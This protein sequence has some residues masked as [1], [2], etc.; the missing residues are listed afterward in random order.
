MESGLVD[1]FAFIGSSKAADALV[2]AGG[3]GMRDLEG[4]R[5]QGK[6]A[7]KPGGGGVRG[8][9][10]VWSRIGGVQKGIGAS[11]SRMGLH[12]GVFKD[13]SQHRVPL[14]S[15]KYRAI[16]CRFWEALKKSRVGGL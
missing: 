7:Q 14:L 15:P 1:I 8:A 11:G 6:L 2:K 9:Q 3:G 16:P 13:I 4:F 5:V 10:E 12:I